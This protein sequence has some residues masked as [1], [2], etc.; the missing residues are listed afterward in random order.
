[1]LAI[2]CDR[3]LMAEGN[4]KISLNEIT[5]GSTVFAGS[6]EIL[7]ALVGQRCT[8][9]IMFAGTMYVAHD[10]QQMG[11]VDR[12]VEGRRLLPQAIAE[13]LELGARDQAAYASM[14]ALLR[15]PIL[16][17]MRLREPQ[18]I[19]EFV[20]IWYSEST[21]KHLKRIEIRP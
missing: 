17:V 20:K 11:L 13:A 12:V 9:E 5:F 1:M 6:T 3:R 18:S 15:E 14:K 10:A 7:R 19:Q 16:E 2:A 21:R 4:G 8:E